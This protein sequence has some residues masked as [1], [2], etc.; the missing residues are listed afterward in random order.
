[1][2]SYIYTHI[3]IIITTVTIEVRAGGVA[4]PPLRPALAGRPGPRVGA[5]D[6]YM[7]ITLILK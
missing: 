7:L 4:L 2:Y 5:G 3:S 1:M 6:D